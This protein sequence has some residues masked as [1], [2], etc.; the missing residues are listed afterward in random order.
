MRLDH[1]DDRARVKH[2]PEAIQVTEDQ[3]LDH[4]TSVDMTA[5]AIS[6]QVV[7]DPRVRRTVT[8]AARR[9]AGGGIRQDELVQEI[10]LE[11]LQRLRRNYKPGR[12]AAPEF[13]LGSLHKWAR[14]AR[15]RLARCGAE[16]P[17][18]EPLS[19]IAVATCEPVGEA[20]VDLLD[21]L[22]RILPRLT[23]SDQR[24][25]ELRLNGSTWRETAVELDTTERQ[26]R[27]QWVALV[28]EVRD[29]GCHS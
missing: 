23:R 12:G 27:R 25:L 5:H 8:S 19:D 13:V 22:H 18:E 15:R 24:L 26:A 20:A 29:L 16:L 10:W 3:A 7:A 9:L 1:L 2:G 11:V 14:S 6:E 17:T 28:V 4:S 21:D